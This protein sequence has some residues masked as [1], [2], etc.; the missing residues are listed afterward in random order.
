[1]VATATRVRAAPS[2]AER[3]SIGIVA[4]A[5]VGFAVHGYTASVPSTTSYLLTIVAIGGIVGL[6]R[7]EPLPDLLA[8]GLALDAVAHLSGGLIR[9]G[10]GV[11]YNAGLGQ[12]SARL[13]THLIQVDHI[14]HTYG[15]AIA[16]LTVWVLVVRPMVDPSVA[17]PAAI[18]ITCVLAGLGVG[19]LNELVEF[20]VTLI[21]TGSHVGGYANTGWDLV[22]NAV[23][24]SVAGAVIWRS[25]ATRR[26]AAAP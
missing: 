5:L 4:A 1:M 15:T 19:A 25:E 21:N 3:I 6:V 7:R 8:Y 11:L 9:V 26:A 24:A 14:V 16:A 10:H 13:E 12:R 17:S 2:R 18:A 23:G 20:I 22:A